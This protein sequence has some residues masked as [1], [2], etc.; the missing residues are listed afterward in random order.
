MAGGSA[1]AAFYDPL[2]DAHVF[3][4]AGPHEFTFFGFAEPVYMEEAGE[5]EEVA[6]HGEPVAEVVAHVVAAEG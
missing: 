4:E 2:E 5:V 3:S 6:L 1:F